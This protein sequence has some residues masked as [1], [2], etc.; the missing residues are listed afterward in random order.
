MLKL[1]SRVSLIVTICLITSC[2]FN[3]KETF[4]IAEFNQFDTDKENELLANDV[5]NYSY[6]E[7]IRVQLPDLTK[8]EL[9]NI[10][11]GIKNIGDN[12]SF[13]VTLQNNAIDKKNKIKNFFQEIVD[14]Q[15]DKQINN[16]YKFEKSVALCE[17]YLE[18]LDNKDYEAFWNMTNDYF[19][20]NLPLDQFIKMSESMKGNSKELGER[21]YHS[22]QYYS[23]SPFSQDYDM[24]TVHY[25]FKYKNVFES[26][27]I[28]FENGN[29]EI[30]GYVYGSK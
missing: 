17:Q 24:Y 29:H 2:S 10:K 15:I 27:A 7:L 6:P 28:H 19:K 8:E 1:F 16:K 20:S 25:K 3:Q 14:L 9:D 30:A 13:R 18:L 22:K 11:W 12:L 23:S 5:M 26:I 4:I 21:E